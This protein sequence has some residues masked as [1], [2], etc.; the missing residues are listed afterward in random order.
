MCRGSIGLLHWACDSKAAAVDREGRPL[1]MRRAS[2][3]LLHWACDSKA[4][5][6]DREGRPLHRCAEVRSAYYIGRAIARPRRSTVK[7]D[8]S[9]CAELRSA[10]Y[11]GRVIARPRRSTVKVDRSIDVPRFDRPTTLGV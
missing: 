11:I 8:R 10:Y 5:A 4:A 2:L 3:G 7:V 9:R 1:Q 6:V